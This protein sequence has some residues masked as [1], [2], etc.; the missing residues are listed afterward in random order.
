MICSPIFLPKG[1][2][3]IFSHQNCSLASYVIYDVIQNFVCLFFLKTPSFPLPSLPLHINSPYTSSHLLFFSSFSS[4]SFSVFTFL[5]EKRKKK[6]NTFLFAFT[7][8][9]ANIMANSL[10]LNGCSSAQCHVF[11]CICYLPQFP[12]QRHTRLLFRI[13]SIILM[14][15]LPRLKERQRESGWIFCFPASSFIYFRINYSIQA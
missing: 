8:F 6:K 9:K 2:K 14:T 15:F 11:S 1:R 13:Q 4:L 10:F 3:Y 12:E 5:L 7:F